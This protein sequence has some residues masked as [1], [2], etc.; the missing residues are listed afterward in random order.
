LFGDMEKNTKT[1]M[2]MNLRKPSNR[3]REKNEGNGG[4]H[5]TSHV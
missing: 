3:I 4:I 2:M 1:W 5:W